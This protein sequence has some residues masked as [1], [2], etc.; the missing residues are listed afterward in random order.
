MVFVG[1][2]VFIVQEATKLSSTMLFRIQLRRTILLRVAMVFGVLA[3][4][5]VAG[6]LAVRMNAQYVL[7]AALAPLFLLVVPRLDLA[8]LI[9]LAA[10]A[11]VRFTLSTGTESRLVASLL[12]T[13]LLV[14]AWVFRMLIVEKRLRL[15]PSPVNGPLLGFLLVTLFSL[16]WGILYRDPLVVTWSSFPFVQLASTIVMVMLPGAFLLVANHIEN[17]KLLKAMVAIMLF[18][19]VLGLI[20]QY[21]LASLPI[22]VGGLFTMWIITL[23]AALALFNRGIPL[24][25]RG[26]LLV[27]AAIWVYWGFG[28]HISWLAG[29]LPGLVALGVLAF[30]RSKKLLVVILLVLAIIVGSNLGY[31]L[32]QQTREM[33]ESGNTR[34]EAWNVNWRVTGKHLL[35]GTGPAGYAAYYMSYFPNDAM[36]SHSNLIDILAQTGVVGFVLCMWFFF[37][38]AWTGYRLATRLRGRGTFTEALANASLAGTV[39]CIISLGFGDWLFP[40]AYTQTI[41]GFDHAVY[42]WLFMGTTLALDRLTLTPLGAEGDD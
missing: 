20:R 14:G 9:I 8:P 32:N 16:I 29:W 10:A 30:M 17:L 35:F 11:F 19:G 42:S 22:N 4:V 31:Y 15:K 12:L 33:N 38:L 36:A 23:S 2:R 3:A 7:V 5:P 37:S 25:A 41:A 1:R 27:L 13:M 26:L 18:A 6:V 40:F 24:L 21:G 34:L 39:A 28:L